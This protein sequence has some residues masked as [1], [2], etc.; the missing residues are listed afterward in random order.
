MILYPRTLRPYIEKAFKNYPIIS[1]LGPRQSG[2]TTLTRQ[3]FPHLPYVSL[4]DPDN[5]LFAIQDPR[6]FLETYGEGAIIDEAQNVPDL[7]SYLQSYVDTKGTNGQY[8]L[9]GSQNFLLMEKISQSLAGRVAIF[10][11]MPLSIE[12]LGRQESPSIHLLK[13][14]YPRLHQQGLDASEY[15]ANYVMTYLERDVRQIKNILDMNRFDHF[16]RLCA[17][18]AGQLLNYSSL[19]DEAGISQET[20]K[21]WLSLLE[22]S[23][24]IQILRP[25]HRNFNKRITK[26]PK[27]Y[28]VDTGL[29]CYLLGIRT[30]EQ[31]DL[32]PLRGNIFE[33]FVISEIYKFFLN[34]NQ[35]PNLFFWQDQ[36]HN[37]IDCI[38][39]HDHQPLPIEIKSGK[40]IHHSFFDPINKWNKLS[41]QE[42]SLLIYGG[43]SAQKRTASCVIPWFDIHKELSGRF[44]GR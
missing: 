41:G 23:Y 2:K 18:R 19:G 27:L 20:V 1:V 17:G 35:R 42:D 40:T 29:V 21:S 15:Y 7:F 4:E 6:G 3:T 33:N 26:T 13:G 44:L 12:E 28:F 11:L 34:H 25:H 36:S 16:I 31:I 22:A 10:T 14:G 38:I 43:N 24:I 30:A 9:S 39:E 37:E 8:V 32:H 5:R